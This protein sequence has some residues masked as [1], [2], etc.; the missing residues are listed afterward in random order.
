MRFHRAR[1]S[2]LAPRL[3]LA[4]ALCAVVWPAFAHAVEVWSLDEEF[5]YG[6][7]I[8]PISLALLWWQR[9][10]L[11]RSMGRGSGVGLLIV[12]SAIIFMLISRRT[13]INVLD[14]LA[15][16]PLLIGVTV[17]LWGWRAGRV[18][19]FPS[20]FLLFGLGLYRGLLSSV[21]F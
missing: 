8:P 9:E 6:F 10:A 21:G 4:L 3:A 2:M 11:S 16:T 14:G 12:A 15:V 5:T 13:G 7:L 19:A 17:Y 18:V 1:W 20:A